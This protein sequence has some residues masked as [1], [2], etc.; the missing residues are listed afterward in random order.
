VR[1]D[2]LLP[3][4][5][6]DTVSH[7]KGHKARTT[8]TATR[9]RYTSTTVA[10]GRIDQLFSAYRPILVPARLSSAWCAGGAARSEGYG[11]V[12]SIGNG[13]KRAERPGAKDGDR[14]PLLGVRPRTDGGGLLLWTARAG[15]ELRALL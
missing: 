10:R 5:E 13:G 11:C 14:C 6:N 7:P 15:T 4:V 3:L 9:S 12:R 8:R 2:P 1:I